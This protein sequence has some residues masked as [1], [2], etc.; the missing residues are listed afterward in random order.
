M[1]SKTN[2]IMGKGVWGGS[3]GPIILLLIMKGLPGNTIS[4]D[5]AANGSL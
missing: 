5:S 1:S 3:G 2:A 4:N